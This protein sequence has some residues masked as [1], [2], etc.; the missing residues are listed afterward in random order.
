LAYCVD[1]D[2]GSRT[3][4]NRVTLSSV[5]ERILDGVSPPDPA[6][7]KIVAGHLRVL[8]RTLEQHA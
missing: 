3:E 4:L 7:L 5:L 8:A 1:N 6:R 2:D